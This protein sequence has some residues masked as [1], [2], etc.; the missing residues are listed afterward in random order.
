MRF[1][2]LITHLGSGSNYFC[3]SLSQVPTVCCNQTNKVYT[4]P[5]DLDAL[6]IKDRYAKLFFDTIEF[7]YSFASTAFYDFSKFIYLIRNPKQSLGRMI[8]EG[9]SRE[10]A[11][12]YY[13]FRLRR[14]YEMAYQTP[15]SLFL[16]YEDMFKEEGHKLIGDFL[17]LNM[18]PIKFV[19]E[20]AETWVPD[21]GYDK[22]L[23]MFKKLNLKMIDKT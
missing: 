8:K 21:N 9:Y 11:V 10:S 18:P 14:M 16:T 12:S 23:A 1:V 17:E 20:Y 19:D 6:K 22:Y 4:H 15:G 2:F 3:D 5:T 13:L 7:N